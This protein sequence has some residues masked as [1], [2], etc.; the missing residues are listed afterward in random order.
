MSATHNTANGSAPE[1][2]TQQSHDEIMRLTKSTPWGLADSQKF[3]GGGIVRVDTA[4]HGGYYV[5]DRHLHRIP[6]DQQTWAA[7]WSGSRNWFEEDCC[8]S[9]VAVAFPELFDSESLETARIILAQYC[10]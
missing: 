5:P 1:T 3:I 8:W 7:R 2:P 9:A 6:Q 10:V 4:S